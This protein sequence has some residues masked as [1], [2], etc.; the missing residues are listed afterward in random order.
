[1]NY[2]LFVSLHTGS[3]S[4]ALHKTL[5]TIRKSIEQ[6]LADEGAELENENLLSVDELS[7]H[8]DENEEYTGCLSNG[9]WFH[10]QQQRG[11]I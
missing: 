5:V 7:E 1:M 2:L 3:V 8:L 4:N 10:I 6:L 11:G 9:T